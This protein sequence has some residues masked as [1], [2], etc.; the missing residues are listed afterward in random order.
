MK[1]TDRQQL[2]RR[3]QA[4]KQTATIPISNP[5]SPK[6]PPSNIHANFNTNSVQS[7]HIQSSNPTP[8]SLL[9]SSTPL[10]I[11]T[12]SLRTPIPQQCSKPS[13]SNHC[14]FSLS[15]NKQAING[16]EANNGIELTA[17][18]WT[19]EARVRELI[20]GLIIMVTK[21]KVGTTKRLREV[22]LGLRDWAGRAESAI[23]VVR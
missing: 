15:L 20:G 12:P 17:T 14:C 22:R 2:G 16:A 5:Q 23:V 8:A 10:P 4:S 1:T 13:S 18:S 3:H 19:L 7:T 6:H 9:H 21:K 11:N